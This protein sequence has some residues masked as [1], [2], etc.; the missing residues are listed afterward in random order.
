ME[1]GQAQ[2]GRGLFAFRRSA[3][4]DKARKS[5]AQAVAQDGLQ[6]GLQDVL[7]VPHAFKDEMT[8]DIGLAL[9]AEAPFAAVAFNTVPRRFIDANGNEVMAD[10]AH[11]ESSYFMAFTRASAKVLRQGRTVQI[12]G[13]DQGKRKTSKLA[14]ADIILS[15]GHNQ[16]PA[17]MRQARQKLQ[18]SLARHIELYEGSVK[19]LGATTNVQA[20]ALRAM[21]YQRFIHVEMS[22]AMRQAMRDDSQTRRNWINA[23]LGAATP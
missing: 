7:Q 1:N 9:F 19:E 16:P 11:L 8:R 10:M 2:R 23:I 3:A 13:F 4:V 5:G 22:R 6:D 21:A 17:S 12:H 20:A 14:E 18:Q 15:A